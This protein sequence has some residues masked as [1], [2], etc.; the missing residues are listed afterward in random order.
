MMQEAFPIKPGHNNIVALTGLKRSFK[1][2]N[3]LEIMFKILMAYTGID[4]NPDDSLKGLA[5]TGT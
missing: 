2:I 4:V 5:V 1:F 3:Y